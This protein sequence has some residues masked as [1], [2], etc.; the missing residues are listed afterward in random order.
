MS[1]HKNEEIWDVLNQLIC[2]HDSRDNSLEYKEDEFFKSFLQLP[3]DVQ[4]DE[5]IKGESSD[6][7][8]SSSYNYGHVE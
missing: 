5:E 8:G 1:R 3:K 7:G 6:T 4:K 2:S